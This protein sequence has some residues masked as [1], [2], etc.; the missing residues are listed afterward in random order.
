VLGGSLMT[1]NITTT[2]V[3]EITLKK[4]SEI[5]VKYDGSEM[6]GVKSPPLLMIGVFVGVT[7][8]A[9]LYVLFWSTVLSP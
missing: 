3:E 5:K 6:D 4:S 9:I 7:I 8:L 1:A 2:P